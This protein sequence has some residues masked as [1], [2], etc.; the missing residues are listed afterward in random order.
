MIYLIFVIVGSIILS[1][2]SIWADNPNRPFG[3]P[4]DYYKNVVN[5]V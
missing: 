3:L 2:I 1:S 5:N 4:Y